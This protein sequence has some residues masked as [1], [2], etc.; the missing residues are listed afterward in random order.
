MAM[1]ATIHENGMPSRSR[2]GG[3]GT[4]THCRGRG[5]EGGWRLKRQSRAISKRPIT[6]ERKA[7]EK[8]GTREQ[9]HGDTGAWGCLWGWTGRQRRKIDAFI[10]TPGTLQR[11]KLDRGD[12]RL[13]GEARS[14][15]RLLLSLCSSIRR[16]CRD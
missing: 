13:A 10:I 15:L 9:G 4:K 2:R 16:I 5:G 8:N 1:A 3:K 6:N 12:H 14:V 7:R 11:G